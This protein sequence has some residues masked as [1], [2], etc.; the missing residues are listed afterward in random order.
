M[1]TLADFTVAPGEHYRCGDEDYQVTSVEQGT[2]QLRSLRR[3][4]MI[5][6]KSID[7]F[8]V[9][10]S[11]G[12][13]IKVAEAPLKG[14]PNRI[15]SGLSEAHQHAHNK[16]LAYVRAAEARFG[17]K[18]P[19][20]ETL[21]LIN[22]VKLERGDAAG[23]TYPTLY[24]WCRAYRLAG[25]S[26]IAL[27]PRPRRGQSRISRQ[28]E[29]VR[30]VFNYNVELFYL[31]R[32][33]LPISEV[34]DSI[35]A[36]LQV[37]NSKRPVHQQVRIPSYS[38]FYRLIK[39]LDQFRVDSC[40]HGNKFAKQRQKWSK[41]A[42]TPNYLLEHVECDSQRV[43]LQLV[44]DQ[45]RN[46]GRAWLTVLLEVT[47]RRIIG[48]DLSHNHPSIEKTIRAIKVSLTPGDRR[49]AAASYTCDN[50]PDFIK[51]KLADSLALIGARVIFCEPGL[52]DQKPHVERWFKTLNTHLTH[53]LPGTTFSNPIECGDYESKKEAV[54]TLEQ[55]TELF[56][57]WLEIYHATPHSSLDDTSPNDV[58]DNNVDPCFPPKTY[59]LEDIHQ[60]FL[61]KATA[62]PVNGRVRYH[63]LQWTCP[64]I[65]YLSTRSRNEVMLTFFYDVS[66]LG[67]I[68]VCD[69]QDSNKLYA[70]EAVDPDYQVG[71]TMAMHDEIRAA[72]SERRKAFSFAKAK[73]QRRLLNLKM[74]AK[75]KK[76]THK[77]KDSSKMAKATATPERKPTSARKQSRPAP[78]RLP[79]TDSIP[80]NA[81]VVE[82]RLVDVPP[83]TTGDDHEH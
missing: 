27:V 4:G 28:P 50:G 74:R 67:T 31:T 40:Q 73:E 13:Y 35:I 3:T 82:V 33:P 15:V 64:A 12:Y 25:G 66:E 43:D 61:S 8:K 81:E 22:Q 1:R 30:S 59:S 11:R 72:M 44:D 32:T 6:C 75:H 69:P 78:A 14:Q 38:T 5:T 24:S 23:P 37:D 46:I 45:G 65:P 7:R 57:Q 36:Q 2:V 19:V 9:A 63:H 42:K 39:E 16:R 83:T 29:E 18:L 10:C 54:Y 48:W 76:A 58:W 68:W 71:L 17:T 80:N 52:P 49:G 79:F 21:Q 60:I 53:N 26:A 77:P 55:F 56:E 41:K 47:S 51:K 34:I 20:D 62:K 70:A